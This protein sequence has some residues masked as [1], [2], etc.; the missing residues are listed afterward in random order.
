MFEESE[1]KKLIRSFLLGEMAEEERSRFEERFL[2][3]QELFEEIRVVED[4]LI[5]RYV[6]DW[7][8]EDERSRF[9]AHFLTTRKRRERVGFSRR[10]I[11]RLESEGTAPAVLSKTVEDE[12]DEGNFWS[13]LGGLFLRPQAAVAAFGLLVVLFGGWMLYRYAGTQTPEVVI[14]DQNDNTVPAASP[15]ADGGAQKE[16]ISNEKETEQIPEKPERET[17]EKNETPSETPSPVRDKTPEKTPVPV[18]PR[19]VEKRAPNPVLALFA[20]TLR[21]DGKTN[22]LKLPRTASGATLRLNLE[23]VDYKIYQ[24]RLTDAAGNE[25]FRKDG[26]KPRNSKI[27]LFV[28][29]RYLKGGDYVISLYGRNESGENESVADFQFRVGR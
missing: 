19:P 26:L 13:R 4:D 17:I 9:E 24:T 14:I 23:T 22:V 18:K 12:E 21:S 8:S 7:M 16:P 10:L 2:G 15:S 25:S 27:N 20:G 6:R 29:A 28:P 1:N 5:E 11:R 3:E